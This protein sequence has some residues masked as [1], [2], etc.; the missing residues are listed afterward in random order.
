MT[1]PTDESRATPFVPFTGEEITL[2]R[3]LREAGLPWTPRPGH[4]VYDEK[5]I[6]D[7]PSPF[8]AKVYFIL[9]MKHFLRRSGSV[10]ELKQSLTWLPTWREARHWLE[11]AGVQSAL[12]QST[13][14]SPAVWRRH[15][16]L[17][18]LLELMLHTLNAAKT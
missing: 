9:D 10:E 11:T 1:D 13:I 12:V 14:A 4:Y 17:A 16:E 2:A 6:I 7:A 8:Q 3:R 15:G 5:G 18:A